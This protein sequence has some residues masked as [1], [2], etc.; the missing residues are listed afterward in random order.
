MKQV[1]GVQGTVGLPHHRIVWAINPFE[2]DTE[3]L[4][5]AAWAVRGLSERG[6]VEVQPVYVWAPEPLEIPVDAG[7]AF[8]ENL[9]KQ[10]QDTLDSVIARV[11]VPGLRSVQVVKSEVFTLRSQARALVEF[12]DRWKASLLVVASHGRNGLK[13]LFLG[14]F[15]ETLSLESDVPMFLVHPGVKRKPDFKRI[16][17]ST[18]FSKE[19]KEAF[20][21]V[22]DF[23]ALHGSRVLIYHKVLLPTYGTFE[24][25]FAVQAALDAALVRD[26]KLIE[27]EGEALAK[28]ASHRGIQAHVLIDRKGTGSVAEAT[29]RQAKR[30]NAMIALASQSGRI[31]TSLLG[32]TTRK[33]LR[34]SEQPVWVLHSKQ[35]RV[36]RARFEHLISIREEDIAKAL[37][38]P[39]S[40][41]A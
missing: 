9:R 41:H 4:R 24:F 20:D 28:L 15:A 21:Q 18:D 5:S 32:S 29:L 17:F 35:A 16:L 39:L 27:D 6:P 3:I 1:K 25:A 13:R 10:A 37:H 31:T 38:L 23:A 19:S 33:V 36:A 7:S 11:K 26:R 12:S 30:S 22:L 2:D 40:R 8:M 34:H 14:S